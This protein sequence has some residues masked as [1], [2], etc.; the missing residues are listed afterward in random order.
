MEHFRVK[1]ICSQQ[2]LAFSRSRVCPLG[3][4]GRLSRLQLWSV[5]SRGGWLQGAAQ[6]QDLKT[7]RVISARPMA[8]FRQE[9]HN[10]LTLLICSGLTSA[11][12]VL[13]RHET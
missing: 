1:S 2:E 11:C 7:S 3:G 6:S 13:G 8:A 10:S 9:L 12:F 4:R 5:T